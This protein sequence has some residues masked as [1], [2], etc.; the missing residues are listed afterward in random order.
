VPKALGQ[1]L[2]VVGERGQRARA[3]R[4]DDHAVTRRRWIAVALGGA[5]V[6]AVLAAAVGWWYHQRSVTSNVRGSSTVEFAPHSRP[7]LKPRPAKVVE[8]IPWPTYGYDD[9]RTRVAPFRL[10]PPFRQRWFYRSGHLLEFPPVVTRD[11]VVGSNQSGKVFALDKVTGKPVWIRS[12]GHCSAA[13]PAVAGKLIYL[14]FMS[15]NPCKKY[16]RTQRG[17]VVAVNASDGKQVWL[18]RLSA[19]ESSPLVVDGLVY[20]GAWDGGVYA[21]D[22]RTGKIRWRTQTDG[23]F[24][25]SAAYGSGT[26]FIGNN[27]GSLWALNA[28]TG[29]VRWTA[30]SAGGFLHPRE[31]FYATPAVAYGRVYAGNTDGSVY[32]FGASTGHLLWERR[33]GTYVYTA[34][35]VWD[36]KVFVG[37]Y[38]GRFM[39]L[40]AATGEI[41]WSYDAPSSVHG[42]S[43]VM[44]GLVYFATCG[45]CGRYGIRHS[46]QG[47]RGTYALNARSGKRVW[48]FGDGQYSP[49]VA[50]QSHLYL[51]GRAWVYGLVPTRR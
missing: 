41:V 38:D 4:R 42:A 22:A 31:Y 16:P 27:A 17:F 13:S 14:S 25:S 11:L 43:T 15:T 10:S 26:V 48:S 44:N 2:P 40:D 33:A 47:P 7:Q 1:Y 49:V 6:L 39:A 3:Q 8:A 23:E 51:I 32:A 34:P 18:R 36:R 45:T 12:W 5:V 35:A 9:Q 29:A 21:L 24:N 46:K 20:V 28:K 37:T 19:T 30:R 50:D